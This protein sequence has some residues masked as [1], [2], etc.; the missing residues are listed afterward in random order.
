MPALE[1]QVETEW[2]QRTVSRTTLSFREAAF[3]A[4]CSVREVKH[5]VNAGDRALE[6]GFTRAEILNCGGLISVTSG[7]WRR[8]DAQALM[9]SEPLGLPSF[10]VLVAVLNGRFNVPP[11]ASDMADPEPLSLAFRFIR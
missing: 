2:I 10:E 3:V 1:L 6:L 9:D 4:G 5:R 7:G 8:V 11:P